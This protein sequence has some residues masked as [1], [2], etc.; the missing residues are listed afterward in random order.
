MSKCL[1]ILTKDYII[2]LKALSFLELPRKAA[3][4]DKLLLLSEK[5][6]NILKYSLLKAPAQDGEEEK[7]ALYLQFKKELNFPTEV[8][9]HHS[10][11]G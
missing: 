11:P 3:D 7:F 2:Y 8:E 9:D 4:F 1:L 6:K 5:L 10:Q